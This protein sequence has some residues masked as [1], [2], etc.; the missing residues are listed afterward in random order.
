MPLG[1]DEAAAVIAA[2]G[3]DVETIIAKLKAL[4]KLTDDN[5][6]LIVS[7]GNYFVQFIAA[8]G[9]EGL[10]FEA[11]SNEFLDKNERID[12]A[13]IA[14]LLAF[15]FNKPD[16]D[17][18]NYALDFTIENDDDYAYLAALAIAVLTDVYNISSDRELEY[19]SGGG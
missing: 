16:G 2:R 4:V 1:P 5:N 13:S 19:E 11:V 17:V 14:K 6:F 3:G 9:Y 10:S 7:V 12:E 18:A 8:A 15:D